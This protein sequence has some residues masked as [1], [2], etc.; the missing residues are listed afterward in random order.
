MPARKVPPDPKTRLADAALKLLAKTPWPALTL[1]AVAKSA[2]VP[3]GELQA[4]CGSKPALLGLI[5]SR[6]GALAAARYVPEPGSAHDRLFESGMSW[7]EAL[8]P[9]KKAVASIYE[10]LKHDPVT[11]LAAR[12]EIAAAGHWL[13]TLAEADTGPGLPLR[14]LAI[15]AAIG[16]AVPVWLRDDRNLTRTMASLDMNLRRGETLLDRIK[17]GVMRD[18]EEEEE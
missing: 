12:G 10:G 6:C 2:R 17:R 5:L 9:H 14:A 16:R 18:D 1:V 4:L 7:F 13:L 15:A 8:T 11:L 3:L